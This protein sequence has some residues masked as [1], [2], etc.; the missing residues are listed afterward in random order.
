MWIVERGGRRKL[1]GEDGDPYNEP[2]TPKSLTHHSIDQAVMNHWGPSSRVGEV[3]APAPG[4]SYPRIYRPGVPAVSP[5]HCVL[6]DGAV[7]AARVLFRRLRELLEFIEPRGKNLNAYGHETRNLLLLASNEVESAWTAVLRENKYARN[8]NWTVKD[9]VKLAVPMRLP[10]WE[11][12]LIGHPHVPPMRPFAAWSTTHVLPWYQA[13][14]K[15]K[16]D[17]ESDFGRATLQN[18][19][20]ALAGVFVMVS[21]QFG[22][23]VN[24]RAGLTPLKMQLWSP[25]ERAVIDTFRLTAEPQ[26]PLS[27]C[28]APPPLVGRAGN[29]WRPARYWR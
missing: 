19:I 23:W 22:T 15:T 16:H 1:H 26:W 29:D 12:A 2:A 8:G 21:A 17:R 25:E 11:V 4:R 7:Q 27:E 3:T 13:Y 14:N 5:K 28:Y 18:C 10:E 24:Y 6:R 20:E 9:Y